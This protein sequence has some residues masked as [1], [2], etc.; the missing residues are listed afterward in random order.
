MTTI[1]R[2][3]NVF[4]VMVQLSVDPESQRELVELSR[5]MIPVFEQQPGFISLDLLRSLDGTQ[6]VTYLQWRSKADHEACAISPEVASA[7]NAFMRFL[8]SGKATMEV[9][10][11]EIIA[12]AGN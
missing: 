9:K 10:T 11:Y 5:N 7:G 4:T 1:S 3:N 12:S 6:I 8:E 2:N